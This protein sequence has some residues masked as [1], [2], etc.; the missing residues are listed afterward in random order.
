MDTVG[1]EMLRRSATPAGADCVVHVLPPS[2]VAHDALPKPTVTQWLT[3]GQ[4]MLSS[5][6]VPAGRC[7]RNQ[8]A[9]PLVVRSISPR[10][11]PVPATA[12]AAQTCAVGQA[13]ALAESPGTTCAVHRL[14]PSVVVAM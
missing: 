8:V 11:A 6:G 7:W 10:P 12:A 4:L 5:S 9:P 13:T 3:E 1:H 2:V 14:P